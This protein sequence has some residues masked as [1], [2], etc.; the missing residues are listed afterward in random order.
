[1]FDFSDPGPILWNA[2]QL[3]WL[4]R[5][6]SIGSGRSLEIAREVPNPA[7][8]RNQWPDVSKRLHSWAAAVP[9]A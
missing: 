6:R 8:F 9:A 2:R 1:M 3:L 4:Q 5:F 7:E